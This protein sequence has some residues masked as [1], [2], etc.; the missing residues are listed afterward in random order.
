MIDCISQNSESVVISIALIAV[1]I[2]LLSN[3]IVIIDN[4]RLIHEIMDKN[5]EE[6]YDEDSKTI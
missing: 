3:I 6:K 2:M 1:M 5:H 4:S